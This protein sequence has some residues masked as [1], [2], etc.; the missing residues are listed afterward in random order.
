MNFSLLNIKKL[1]STQKSEKST[2]AIG[3]D[4][5]IYSNNNRIIVNNLFIFVVV[6]PGCKCSR[7]VHLPF[8]VRFSNFEQF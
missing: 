8:P 2:Q 5:S 7:V 6:G 1:F 3:T 4:L